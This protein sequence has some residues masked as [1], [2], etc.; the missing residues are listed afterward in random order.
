M[1]KSKYIYLY[2]NDFISLLQLIKVLLIQKTIPLNIKPD[3]YMPNLFEETFKIST[4]ENDEIIQEIIKATSPY[5]LSTMYKIY[6]SEHNDKELLIFYFFIHALKYKNKIY[7]M[8][9]YKSVSEALKVEKYVEHETHKFKGFL[10]F[11]ELKGGTLYANIEPENNIIFFISKHFKNRLKNEFWII[12]DKKRNLISI[13]DKN[14]FY[15]TSTEKF[16]ILEKELSEEEENIE[17]LWKNFYKT[18]A[19]KERTNHRCRMNFMP[20][21]YWKYIIEMSDENEKGNQ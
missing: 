17:S 14:N 13:Y 5:I 8:R 16:K 15:I 1:R 7:F 21:K 4:Q 6:L 11:K 12:E 3:T 20:K 10:R 9:N 19:I 18:I 2:E